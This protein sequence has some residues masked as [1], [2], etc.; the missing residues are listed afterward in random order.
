MLY[1]APFDHYFEL[2]SLEAFTIAALVV[3]NDQ[4][5]QMSW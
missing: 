2:G 3:N 4:Q 1:I 5:Q